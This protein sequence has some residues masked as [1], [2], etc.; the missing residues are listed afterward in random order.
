MKIL[1]ADDNEDNRVLQETVLK[2]KGY[3]MES[4]NN[5]KHAL[6]V[7]ARFCPDIIVSD[8]LMPEMDG[9]D[10]CRAKPCLCYYY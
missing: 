5:G 9:F 2:A 4:A 6:E 7:L 1:I 3:T 8:I 10:L